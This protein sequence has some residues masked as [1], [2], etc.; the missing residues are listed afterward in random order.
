M[1]IV[2][3]QR[4]G[5]CLICKTPIIS[6]YKVEYKS[7]GIHLSCYHK[8]LSEKFEGYKKQLK[9]FNKMKYK[10]IMILECIE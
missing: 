2:K 8:W 6:K 4:K 1:E 9:Q 10:K 5:R 3:N 7:G